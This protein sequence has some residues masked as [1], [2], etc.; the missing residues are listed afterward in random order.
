MIEA[1]LDVL[2]NVSLENSQKWFDEADMNIF[3]KELEQQLKL[4]IPDKFLD[5]YGWK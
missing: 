3:L 1:V 2:S 4:R 5:F